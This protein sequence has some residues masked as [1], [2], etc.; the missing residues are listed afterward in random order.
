M[1]A[2]ALAASGP[3]VVI[4]VVACLPVASV[5]LTTVELNLSCAPPVM[6]GPGRPSVWKG[7]GTT[8][9]HVGQGAGTASCQYHMALLLS[10]CGSACE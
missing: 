8:V 7:A 10:A 6:P 5:A 4:D 1:M 9:L 2:Q 3:E